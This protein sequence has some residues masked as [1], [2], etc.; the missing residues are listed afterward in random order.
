LEPSQILCG[1]LRSGFANQ[2]HGTPYASVNLGISREFQLAPGDKP[3]TAR[4]DIVNAF[5]QVYELRTGTDI[6]VFAPQFGPRRGYYFGL[7]Q[8]L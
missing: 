2:D 3:V 7:S 6:G 5:D 1:G 4:F 8:K